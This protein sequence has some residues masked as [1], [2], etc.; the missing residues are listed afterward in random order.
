MSTFDTSIEDTPATDSTVHAMRERISA[1]FGYGGVVEHEEILVRLRDRLISGELGGKK[2]EPATVDA[3]LHIVD[4]HGWIPS[5]AHF[6]QALPHF[7]ECFGLDEIRDTC[8]RLGLGSEIRRMSPAAIAPDLLPAIFE[9]NGE[10]RIIDKDSDGTPFLLSPENEQREPIPAKAETIH[11]VLFHPLEDRA[12]AHDGESSFWALMD[13]FRSHL[14]ML[15]LVTFLINAMM[16]L[17]SFAVMGIYDWVLPSS[18]IDTLIAMAI[19]TGL[20]IVLEIG[21]R[22]LRADLIG[23]LAG[24]IDYLVSCLVFEKLLSLPYQMIASSPISAQISSMKQFENFRDLVGGPLVVLTLD[25]PFVGLLVLLLFVIGGPIGFIALGLIGIYVVIALF[26]VPYLKIWTRQTARSRSEQYNFMLSTLSKLPAIRDLRCENVWFDRLEKL[27]AD[28]GIAKLRVQEA[29]RLL[30]TGSS[31]IMNIAGGMTVIFGAMRVMEGA[32]TVGGLVFVTILIWRV[33]API[34]QGFLLLIRFSEIVNSI[35][36]FD[37]FMKLQGEDEDEFHPQMKRFKGKIEIDRLSF[38][39]Q[40]AAE[41]TLINTSLTVQP[42]EVVAIAG[43]SGCGKSS[44]LKL[45][46]NLYQPQSGSVRVDGTNVRQIPA[47][48]LRA[49]IG[50]LQ[51]HPRVFHGTVAQNLRLCAPGASNEEL[52]AVTRDLG[53]YDYIMSLPNGF[54]TR[55]NEASQFTMHGAFN[56]SLGLALAVLRRLNI[57]LLD[58][59]PQEHGAN[60]DDIFARFVESCRGNTT[61]LMTT[62]HPHYLRLA[63]RVFVLEGGQLM[64]ANVGKSAA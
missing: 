30:S 50:Y 37:R 9:Y 20:I 2:L 11:A 56:Q 39:Y 64:E 14:S 1:A 62:N 53:I 55:L 38:R 36:Q 27:M 15:L 21:F 28:T 12:L 42:G 40:G 7:P 60:V 44:I 58:E 59:P 24:R 41:A 31:L 34:Q 26:F 8:A 33:I 49:N 23:N 63:D 13:R 57:I 4:S 47:N 18:A 46:L 5:V 51:Q 48:E 29:N 61:I 32:M 25:A 43:H 35:T 10:I 52:H 6:A 3:L 16:I 45:I 54:D 17:S 22:K 19:G